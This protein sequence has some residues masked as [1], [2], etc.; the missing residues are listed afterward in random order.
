MPKNILP[1]VLHKLYK[2]KKLPYNLIL[3]DTIC[4]QLLYNKRK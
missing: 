1:Q 4:E 3:Y 2:K